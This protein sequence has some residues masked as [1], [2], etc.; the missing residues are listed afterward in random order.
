MQIDLG[1]VPPMPIRITSL[2]KKMQAKL[3]ELG[4]QDG[5]GFVIFAVVDPRSNNY[6][7]RKIVL[8]GK[9]FALS[10]PELLR[11]HTRINGDRMYPVRFA[12]VK[13]VYPAQA[14][15]MREATKNAKIWDSK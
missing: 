6:G 10:V 3:E 2:T 9:K 11:R 13:W 14:K 7:K 15:R 5:D 1:Y 12:T 4:L 8:G